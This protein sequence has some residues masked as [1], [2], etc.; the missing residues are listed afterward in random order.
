[1]KQLFDFIKAALIDKR[2]AAGVAVFFDVEEEGS[3]RNDQ[4]PKD[5]RKQ[6]LILKIEPF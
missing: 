6:C 2:S 3:N 5:T 1:M 4:K